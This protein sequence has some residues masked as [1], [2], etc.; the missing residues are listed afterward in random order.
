VARRYEKLC[1]E[2]GFCREE[3]LCPGVGKVGA[4]AEYES[5][6]VD[7]GVCYTAC[8]YEA[9]GVVEDEL[10]RRYVT[11]HVEGEKFEVPE[12]VTLK[13]ALELV[14]MRF[15]K[16][17]DE[18]GIYT[19]CETGGCYACAVAVDGELKPLC[20]T[21]VR[22]G[23]KVELDTSGYTPLRIVSGFMPHQ[24]GGVGTPW[25][26]KRSGRRY[27][28][29]ACFAHGCNLRCPQCQNFS[30]T[31]GNADR[32]LTPEEAARMLTGFRRTYGVDRMAISG[33]E[34][35]LNRRWLVRFFREL[36]RMN[37]DERARLHLDTN[38]T[39]LTRDYVDEL[40]E[41]GM[42]DIGPDIKGLRVETFMR[43]TGVRDRRLAER[44]LRNEWEITKYVVDHYYPD[45][46]FVG[47]GIP[48]NSALITVEEV[49][50]MGER[51]AEIDDELQVCVLDY[52]GTFRRRDIGRPSY[53]EMLTVRQA[54]L[55]AGLKTV[56]AQTERGHV[57]P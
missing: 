53:E 8:P 32:P 10:P 31:Y 28:E 39:V 3:I 35:T 12:R 34:P 16:L 13:K 57:G 23:M 26:V 55:E 30:V 33:G 56:I 37:R 46:V 44:Y 43:I 14:G 21:P 15:T 18:P 48:Y 5:A 47:V 17:P 27:V 54:L 40:V 38:A 7:C 22:D 52:Y 2:C 20:T 25:W 49:R 1:V 6:C 45:R 19:P 9:I 42:T 4:A 41:A 51:L 36:R 50:E 24:V 29:V 11:I